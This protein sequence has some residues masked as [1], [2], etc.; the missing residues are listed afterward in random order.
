MLGRVHPRFRTPGPSIV[1]LGLWSALLLLSGHYKELYTLVIFPSWILYAMTAASVIV[2]RWTRPDMVR[3]YK[4]PGY[5]VVPLLFVMVAVCLLY[6]TLR[7]SPRESGI[8]FGIIVAGL[9]FYFYWKR[10]L[11]RNGRPAEPPGSVL[12]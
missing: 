6:S 10:A 7:T 12:A 8:G 3:P 1:L 2:L 5:P 9:P 4:V 11:V